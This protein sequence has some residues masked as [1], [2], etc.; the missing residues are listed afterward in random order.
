[1]A[2]DMLNDDHPDVTKEDFKALRRIYP[3]LGQGGS[4]DDIERN[5][6]YTHIIKN[7]TKWKDD[8]FTDEEI[9]E[10]VGYSKG[11]NVEKK[12]KKRGKPEGFYD[13]PR[14]PKPMQK[15]DE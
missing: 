14:S 11:K 12:E 7:R 13:H 5:N 4:I 1:M 15:D 6:A 3:E 10:M 2:D 9:R 8:P